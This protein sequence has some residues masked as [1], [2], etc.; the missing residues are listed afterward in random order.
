MTSPSLYTAEIAEHI[1]RELRAGRSLQDICL[2]H[3][4]PHRDTVAS[5]IRQ[6]REGFAAR[7]RQAREIARS[8]PGHPGYTAETADRILEELMSGRGLVDICGDPDM[9]DHTAVNRW[10]ATDR[11]GF[12]ARYRSARQVG[13]Q[14]RAETAYAPETAELVLDELVSGRTL[15]DICAD[16]DMPSVASVGRWV[17]DDREGFAARYRDARE[18]GYQIIGDQALRI[19]DDRRNDWIIWRREDGTMARMLDPQ[20][21]NRALA[22]VQTRRWLLSKMLPKQFG[23]RPDLYARQEAN[24]DMAEFMKLLNGRSRGLPSEDEPLD[25]Q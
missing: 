25:Q 11:E 20:R 13:R 4:M 8:I 14:S 18:V 1:L 6:D 21:V 23:D 7:Y 12:A 5:W 9:P 17:R 10:V 2:E 22:R 16:P 3:A 15:Q 24:S 19:V